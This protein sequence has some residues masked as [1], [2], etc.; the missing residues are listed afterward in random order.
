MA[1][2]GTSCRP[3]ATIDAPPRKVR[4]E[5]NPTLVMMVMSTEAAAAAASL[6][7]EASTLSDMFK[8]LICMKMS[9][10]STANSSASCSSSGIVKKTIFSGQGLELPPAEAG[11]EEPVWLWILDCC[12]RH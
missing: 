11:L 7:T 3:L 9:S 5:G 4:A 1:D 8:L 6:G 10:F 12:L 2:L